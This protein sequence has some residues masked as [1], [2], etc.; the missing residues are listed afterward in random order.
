[1]HTTTNHRAIDLPGIEIP[2]AP[3]TTRLR[4]SLIWLIIIGLLVWSWTPTE[5]SKASLLF[6]DWRNMA[7]F[8]SGFLTPK[9]RD[10]QAY[11]HQMV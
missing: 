3:L 6:T 5:M 4:G 8:A 2:K 9:F 11:L 10:W 7:E 1:M